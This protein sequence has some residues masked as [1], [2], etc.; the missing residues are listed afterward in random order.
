MNTQITA[1][2]FKAP[3][4]L[5]EYAEL[6]V[7]KLKQYY[8]G[9]TD[10]HIIL[11][12]LNPALDERQAEIG[13]N[14]YRQKLTSRETGSTHEEAIDRCVDN[15]KRQILKYKDKLRGKHKYNHEH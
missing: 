12:I 7:S 8:D 3:P 13:I 5:R 15:L 14:V 6:R 9:I 4:T 11:D 2:H 10:A 1:R